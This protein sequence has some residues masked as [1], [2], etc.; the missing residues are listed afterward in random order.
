LRDIVD[1]VDRGIMAKDPAGG[2][3]TSYS[4]LLPE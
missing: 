1:L 4:L 3:S 2:R